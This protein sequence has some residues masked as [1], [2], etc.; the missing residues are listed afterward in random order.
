MAFKLKDGS[1]AVPDDPEALFRDLRKK[2]VPGLL[3]HQADALR[4]YLKIHDKHEDIA[5]QLPTGSG[6]TLVG[7]LIGEWRRRKYRERVVYLCPTRQLVHQVADQALSK[8]GLHV[9][10][11][12]GSK[13]D[14]DQTA[15]NEWHGGDALAITTYSSLFN[16]RPFFD[17]ANVIILDDAHSSE[18]YISSCWSVTIDRFDIEHKAAFAAVSSVIGP[19][20]STTDRAHLELVEE[21]ED[22]D[23]RWVDKISTPDLQAV[24]AQ[25]VA[26]LDEHTRDTDSLKYQWQLLRSSLAACHVYVSATQFLIRPLIPPTD[27]HRAF[28]S[29]KQRIYMS[30]TLGAG[31][32]L[33]RT[34][35]RHPIHRLPVPPGWDK[36]GIGR[37]FFQFPQHLADEEAT[38]KFAGAAIGLAG[39]ALYL[40]PDERT[41]K[42]SREWVVKNLGVPVFDARQIEESKEPFVQSAKAVAVIANRYDG[43][44]LLDDECRMLLARGLPRG[45]NLQERFLV[46][47]V[48]AALLLDDR[49]LT[50]VVQGFGRCTRSPNDFSAVIV[51]GDDLQKYLLASERR[52]FFHPEIQAELH[53]GLEQSKELSSKEMLQNLKH[54][55]KQDEEWIA[56]D[57]AI[58]E[59]RSKLTQAKLPATEELSKAVE[60]EIKYQY[61]MWHGNYADALA[62]CRAVLGFLAHESLRGYRAM[63]LYLAGSAALLAFK[64]KAL[65][66]DRL[67]REFFQQAYKAAP[68]L[69]WLGRLLHS[70]R[71]KG[72]VVEESELKFAVIERLEELFQQLGMTHDAKYSAFEGEIL[73]DILQTADGKKF[74]N[75]H[76]KLGRMLGYDAH[77]GDDDAAP[78]PWWIANE[79]FCVVFE[80]YAEAKPETPLPAR[81]A[82]QA[83]GHPNWI[84]DKVTLHKEATIIP[85]VLTLSKVMGKG[86]KPHLK[87]V[88][89]W[90]LQDFQKWAK[91]ALAVVREL[92][93]SYP[94]QPDLMWR[95]EAARRMDEGNIT[96]A[97]LV[98]MLD[99]SAAEAMSEE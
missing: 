83:A 8:Y 61:A 51:L 49:I 39:R 37:R 35:G 29:A 41:A 72:E 31:G 75:G 63:W 1:G 77:N 18:N 56:A 24:E 9:R 57:E 67:S 3:S 53:F 22:F 74:E 96:P 47:R 23:P 76:E 6:K 21:S 34:T 73:R 98:K 20:L 55:L 40:V 64:A 97:Q 93:N 13:R 78:D 11:F 92:R 84:R 89:Y 42:S 44:D 17:N 38:L 30:A 54:F 46:N 27:T 7:L 94:G 43:I 26:V 28:R 65:S 14:Y 85:I 60:A 68:G 91:N 4:S 62:Q 71:V 52:A 70:E 12:V 32:D 16:V 48:G 80:D 59:L 50:R 66:D 33:E 79:R 5:I 81:K 19:L 2:T 99:Q 15:V 69:R 82:R 88:K 95:A 90:N 87:E 10:E 36:Q 45:A 25:L 58:V 86:A